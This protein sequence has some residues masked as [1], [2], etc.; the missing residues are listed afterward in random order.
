[1]RRRKAVVALFEHRN[2]EPDAEQQSE[3]FRITL[4]CPSIGCLMSNSRLH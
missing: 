1:M 3:T 4:R 2:P